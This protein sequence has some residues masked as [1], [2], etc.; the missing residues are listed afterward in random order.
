MNNF[1]QEV[2]DRLGVL[3]EMENQFNNNNLEYFDKLAFHHDHVIR[4]RAICIIAEIGGNKAVKTISKV[5]E[6]DSDELVRHEAAFS[7]GQLG[8][9][10]GIKSLTYALKNDSSIFVRHEA[11]VALGVIG[12]EDARITLIEALNDSSEEVKKSAIVALANLDY[13]FKSKKRNQF[14]RLTGG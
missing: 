3:E 1:S 6:K 12:S 13:I 4:T 11:A 14:T 10:S 7:L 9:A 5:L 8:F 2:Y